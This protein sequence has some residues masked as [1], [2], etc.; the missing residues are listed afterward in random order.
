M[1]PILIYCYDAYC[2]WCYGFSPVIKEIS[3]AYKQKLNC[4]VLSGGMILPEQPVHIRVTAGYIQEAYKTVEDYTGIKFGEDYLW[5]IK[6][7]EESDW[8]PSSEKPA[9]ALSIFKEL[10][11]EQQAQFASDLQY[12]LHYEGRD[13]TDNE[14]YRHLLEKYNIDADDFYIRLKSEEYK[15]KA[16]YEFQLCKQ[17]QVTG[18]PQVLI[19]VTETKFHLLARG[20]TDYDTLR[21]RIDLVLT[22]IENH[23]YN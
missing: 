20:Y 9:I 23:S 18:F 22:E 14:A 4:E 6:N 2:G 13:L 3:E 17:L 21:K 10:F 5:H 12:S 7:P 19:Q 11:P 1:Q 8:F 16:Y 15:E